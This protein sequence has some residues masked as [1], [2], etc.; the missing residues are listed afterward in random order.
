MK[1]LFFSIILIVFASCNSNSQNMNTNTKT[2]IFTE[3]ENFPNNQLAYQNKDGSIYFYNN[4]K[5]KDVYNITTHI[6]HISPNLDNVVN[7]ENL[8]K[9]NRFSYFIPNKYYVTIEYPSSSSSTSVGDFGRHYKL[10]KIGLLEEHQIDFPEGSSKFIYSYNKYGQLLKVIEKPTNKT[11]FEN[12]YDKQARIIEKIENISRLESKIVYTYNSQNQIIKENVKQKEIAPNGNVI[13]NEEYVLIYQYD[14]KNQLVKKKSEDEKKLF[15]YTYNDKGL[16]IKELIYET[17]YKKE[18]ED[19]KTIIVNDFE[20]NIL[21]YNEEKKLVKEIKKEA[22]FNNSTKLINKQWKDLNEKEQRDFAWEEYEQ[23]K[24]FFTLTTTQSY[25]YSGN[26]LINSTK[27]VVNNFSNGKKIIAEE[28]THLEEVVNYVYNN[29][30]QIIKRE[31][32]RTNSNE[33]ETYSYE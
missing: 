33:S 2:E 18:E 17:K 27:K 14:S 29:L 31:I 15:Q 20:E 4:G 16:L 5:Q 3:M 11:L 26:N 30:G 6:L 13:R 21:E 25:Q 8:I 7:V 24:N 19:S 1:A 23:N 28:Q 12:K 22:N 9:L 32:I 10:N